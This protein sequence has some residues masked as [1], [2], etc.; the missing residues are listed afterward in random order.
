MDDTQAT[1]ARLRLTGNRFE[2]E[3]VPVEALAEVVAYRELV[4]GVAKELFRN[5]NPDRQRLPRGF[6]D[7][8]QLRLR[9]VE[10]GSAVPVLERLVDADAM[11][12]SN[13]EFTRARDLIEGAV[14]A[15]AADS[16]LPSSFPHAALVLFNSFDQTLGPGEAIELRRGNAATGPKYTSEIRRRLVLT[17]RPT[18]QNEVRDIGWVSELDTERMTC[19]IRLRTASSVPLRAPVDELTFQPLKE[20]MAPN[21]EGPPVSIHGLGVFDTFRGL[22]RLDS[23]DDVSPVEDPSGLAA[24]DRR[25]LEIQELRAG[26]LDGEGLAPSYAAV[27]LARIVL[28]DLLRSDAPRPRVY[29]TVEG[30]IQAEWTSGNVESSIIFQPDGKIDGMAVDGT[31]GELDE[32]GGQSLARIIE[33]AS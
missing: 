16:A 17:D 3:G 22:I 18:Y 6:T 29:P 15:V 1:F 4:L 11:L 7:R 30:G 27:R 14:K 12:P 20:A 33:P 9:A 25:L 19:T 28:A 21:G 32:A 2:A 5:E 31:T 8:F 23:I 24:L 13:D 10:H 26:W